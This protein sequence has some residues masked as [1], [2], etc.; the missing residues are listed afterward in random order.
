VSAGPRDRRTSAAEVLASYRQWVRGEITGPEDTDEW[1]SWAGQL[2]AE[3]QSLIEQPA[4][5]GVGHR[6]RQPED[7]PVSA[8]PSDQAGEPRAVT[9]L[10]AEAAYQGTTGPR[11][12]F[13]HLTMRDLLARARTTLEARGDY[14]PARHGTEEPEPLTTD[15]H[16]EVLAVGELLAR[17][18]RHPARIHDA[19]LAGATWPQVAAAIGT[20]EPAARQAYRDW[21]DR[22]HS[23]WQHDQG[24]LGL[25]DAE[26]ADAVRRAAEPD[27]EAGQ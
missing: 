19:V 4:D 10:Q 23:L 7:S 22:L 5:T 20:S 25:A 26:H 18:Y 27:P 13:D 3:L 1:S 12:R 17:Y 14:D 8:V 15:E 2:A 6:M 16:L 24:R 21:A 9:Y 11:Q